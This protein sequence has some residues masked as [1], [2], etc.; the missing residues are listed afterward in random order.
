M[1]PQE[2]NSTFEAID[3][4]LSFFPK[5]VSLFLGGTTL[6]YLVGWL[7]AKEYFEVFGATWL[8]D[9][10]STNTLLS[11]SWRSVAFL[12]FLCY[13]A[14]LDLEESDKTEGW[15]SVVTSRGRTIIFVFAVMQVTFRFFDLKTAYIIVS[16]IF[17]MAMAVYAVSSFGLLVVQMKNRD[18]KWNLRSTYL[19]YGILLGGFYLAP[20]NL[21]RAEG[22]ID[23]DRSSLTLPVVKLKNN[24]AEFRL[25]YQRNDTFYIF[26][27]DT[28]DNLPNILVKDKNEI[29]FIG[30][31]ERNK[32]VSKKAPTEFQGPH[33]D[34][35]NVIP[36]K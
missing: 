11:Y 14:T 30:K 34:S 7:Y 17:A 1:K 20:T 13:L 26:T 21:G 27:P 6:A 24:Y 35:I 28:T 16:R 12:I 4:L 31:K 36:T 32:K 23:I 19:T 15:M 18:F 25:L 22:Y 3:R 5:I 2:S 10:L 33:K 8:L 29:E 9:E